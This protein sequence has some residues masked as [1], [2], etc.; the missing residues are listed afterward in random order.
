M[1]RRQGA[2]AD[3]NRY[4]GRKKVHK[5]VVKR[6]DECELILTP[7]HRLQSNHSGGGAPE[8]RRSES[9]IVQ[10]NRK[11]RR[12]ALCIGHLLLDDNNKHDRAFA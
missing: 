9:N 10:Y 6:Y 5:L 11:D 7:A 1:F 4:H 12:D 2:I 8:R 3:F